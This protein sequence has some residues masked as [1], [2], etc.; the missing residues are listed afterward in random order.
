MSRGLGAL[1][2]EIKA[3]LDR[4]FDLGTGVLRFPHCARRS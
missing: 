1:Q 4:A 2:R 3:A